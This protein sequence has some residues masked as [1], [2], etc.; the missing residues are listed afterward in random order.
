[1]RYRKKP[2]KGRGSFLGGKPESLTQLFRKFRPDKEESPFA[3]SGHDYLEIP[4]INWAEA[5]S[6]TGPFD[7]NGRVTK[8]WLTE[9]LARFTIT[10][11][12]VCEGHT[13]WAEPSEMEMEELTN[14]AEMQREHHP[15]S[16]S[17]Q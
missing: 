11:D 9:L 6:C 16:C 14:F 1:M 3:C 17:D 15:A 10:N 8:E 4:S 13:P 5:K 7:A 2:R 12:Q